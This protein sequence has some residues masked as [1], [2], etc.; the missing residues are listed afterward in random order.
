MQ[1]WVLSFSQADLIQTS[2]VWSALT[3]ILQ[4]I[5]DIVGH[6]DLVAMVLL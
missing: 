6:Y 3:D 5:A 1:Y 4:S 2:L